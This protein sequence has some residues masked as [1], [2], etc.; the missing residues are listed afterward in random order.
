MDIVA[1][2]MICQLSV[3]GLSWSGLAPSSKISTPP[4]AVVEAEPTC[5]TNPRVYWA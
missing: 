1:E 5:S 3:A 4:A 2:V